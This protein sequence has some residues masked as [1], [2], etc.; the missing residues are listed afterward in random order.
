M[1]ALFAATTLCILSLA[2]VAAAQTYPPP[3]PQYPPSAAS[4]RPTLP[5]PSANWSSTIEDAKATYSEAQVGPA[6]RAYRA[7]C[8][9]YQ[10]TGFCECVTAGVAQAMPPDLVRMAARTIRERINAQGSASAGYDTDARIGSEN[11]QER[12]QQVEGHY[13]DACSQLRR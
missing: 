10:S 12:I 2:G 5:E 13:A 11:P 4:P 7:A 6:R 1:K 9:R 3:S 8:N